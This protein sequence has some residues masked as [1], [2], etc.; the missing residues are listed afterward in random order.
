MDIEVIKVGCGENILQQRYVNKYVEINGS[1]Y[2]IING[3]PYCKFFA[4][5]IDP[6]F[7]GPFTIKYYSPKEVIKLNHDNNIKILKEN[8]ANLCD[9]KPTYIAG[10][11]L[12]K[13]MERLFPESK[14]TCCKSI[15]SKID[16]MIFKSMT[17][18]TANKILHT[19]KNPMYYMT[20]RIA[21][22]LNNNKQYGRKKRKFF[23]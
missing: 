16:R 6:I 22:K 10:K 14:F 8:L 9:G 5:N 21:E 4:T 13:E 23:Y 2:G 1:I 15:N 11:G 3:E 17:H 12:L 19:I 20:K 18:N 7:D